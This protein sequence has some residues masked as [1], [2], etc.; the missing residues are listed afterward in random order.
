MKECINT[1][2]KKQDTRNNLS[3]H[4]IGFKDGM[5]EKSYYINIIENETFTDI[6]N[7]HENP[8]KDLKNIIDTT[9]LLLNDEYLAITYQN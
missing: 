4:I 3:K 8:L 1:T 7:P 6:D 5:D 2:I 9:K